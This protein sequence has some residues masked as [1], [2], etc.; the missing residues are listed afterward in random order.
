MV[1]SLETRVTKG[2]L[3]L[4]RGED[5]LVVIY[6]R[7]D[8]ELG[9]RYVLDHDVIT[10]GRD[11]DN[12]ISLESDSVSR[13][14][15]RIDHHGDD[16]TLT[17]LSSTNGTFVNDELEPV[18]TRRLCKGDHVKVGHTIFKY[19][20]GADIETQYHEAIFKLTITDGLTD[21]GNAKY[22]HQVLGQEV[23]RARR[24]GR[25]LA[26][27]MIDLDHF[28]EV[29]DTYGH[30]AGDGVLRDVAQIARQRLRPGDTLARYG[31]EEFCAVLPET[32]VQGAVRVASE[33][34][35]QIK[36]YHC[37][38]E[39]QSIQ[40]TVSI[41]AAELR[42]GMDATS[43]VKAADAQLYCAKEQGRNCVCS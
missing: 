19:L 14:H 27:L 6:T 17:D 23:P 33:L 39:G 36:G 28:K 15:A 31:G 9:R 42:D 16:L 35:E 22:L 5:N 2:E 18:T 21:V 38:F 11:P 24:H 4:H 25:H 3:R 30:L 40:V 32:S 12:D 13:F 8:T 26:L 20:S 10:I 43:L 37:M 29:N 34:R 7:S 1:S 41:G